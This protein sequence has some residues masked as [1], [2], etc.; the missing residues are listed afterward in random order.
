MTTVP[1]N[2]TIFM[3]HQCMTNSTQKVTHIIFAEENLY[4]VTTDV[5]KVM[6]IFQ[7]GKCVGHLP[8]IKQQL[9]RTLSRLRRHK[10]KCLADPEQHCD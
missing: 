1:E 9:S 5:V 7:R 2:L 8:Q 10:P 3:S 4:V 6:G